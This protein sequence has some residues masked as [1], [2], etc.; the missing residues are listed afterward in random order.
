MKNLITLIVLF[1]SVSIQAQ[2]VNI[3]DANFKA[4]LIADGVDANNDGEI[5]VSEA[6]DETNIDLRNFEIS[7]LEGI[8]SF[9]NLR[10]LDVSH[11]NLTEIDLSQNTLLVE[12]LLWDNQLTSLNVSTSTQLAYLFCSNNQLT[13]IDLSQNTE[14]T[15]F[16]ASYNQLL[17]NVLNQNPNLI[18]VGLEGNQLESIDLSQSS[19][20]LSIDLDNNNL[21]EIDISQTSIAF[22]SASDNPVVYINLKNG[23]SSD[24]LEMN[25]LNDIQYVCADNINDEIEYVIEQLDYLDDNM[26]WAV[27]SYCTFTPGG[28]FFTIDGQSTID[29][30]AIGC[31][32]SNTIFPYL[33]FNITNGSVSGSVISDS[34]G[35][36]NIHVQE[37]NHFTTPILEN[38]EYYTIEPTSLEVNFPEDGETISQNFCLT[39]NGVHNDL[40]VILTPYGGAVPGFDSHYGLTY[41][42]NGNTILSG[43]LTLNFDDDY[44]DLVSTD[45][46]TSSQDVGVLTW[47][48][49]DLAPFETRRIVIIMNLNTPTDSEFPLNSD[50]ILTFGTEITSGL[51][52]ETPENNLF[53][54][55]QIVV[56]SYD[57]NDKTCLE[58]NTLDIEKVGEYLHYIIRF[59]NTGTANATN[60]VVK[61]ALDL[62][63]YDFASLIPL[64]A[65]HNFVTKVSNDNLVE[66]IFEDINLP[67]DDANN[68]GYVVYKVKT[69]PDLEIGDVIENDAEIYFDFNF[70][71]ITN[72]EQTTVIEEGLSI[73][74]F[75]GNSK[76]RIFPNPTSNILNIKTSLRIE[77]VKLFGLAGQEIRN[78]K[79]SI[80][81]SSATLN[82]NKLSTG[83]YFIEIQSGTT[84]SMHKVLKN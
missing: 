20:L 57:P 10:Y 63:R 64:D 81:N 61:D 75:E 23:V 13:N 4:A 78:I 47:D 70:P 56:N 33:K 3:P 76:V 68:D 84:K 79:A 21:L 27:N 24:H 51:T 19:E 45:S 28:D 58:G 62:T 2:I 46:A 49:T 29:L 36:Y 7:S 39:P 6:E 11:N 60:I 42:N 31:D 59:E 9:V 17:Y 16:Y 77:S 14:L 8:Q 18:H 73:N 72:N 37:G 80:D 44:M 40:E 53:N 26:E 74:E 22:F 1:V 35:Y 34:L 66:F 50:D 67:F 65:S 55:N 41:K 52:D 48:F 83:F 15:E 38:P 12:L 5:Q 82:M 69:L 43:S 71:I 54:F 25:G 30:D 32:V